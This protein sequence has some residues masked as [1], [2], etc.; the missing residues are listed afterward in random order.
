MVLGSEARDQDP[1]AAQV[2]L[3]G[4][5]GIEDCGELPSRMRYAEPVV[6]SVLGEA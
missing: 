5:E 4:P 1:Q 2:H 3:A 6:G